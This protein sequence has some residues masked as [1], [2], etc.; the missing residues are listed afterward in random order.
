[1]NFL[2]IS[3]LAISFASSNI[4][5]FSPTLL[6]GD[7][8]VATEVTTATT[9][10]T[11]LEASHHHNEQQYQQQPSSPKTLSSDKKMRPSLSS[12]FSTFRTA[13]ATLVVSIFLS[14]AALSSSFLTVEPAWA[15]SGGGLDYAGIDISGQ[16]F[17]SS[18]YKGKDFT[19]VIAKGT[20][21]AGSNLQGCRFYKAFLVSVV[22]V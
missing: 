11:Y 10:T 8:F 12:S 14:Q 20:S 19:Q 5:A 17:S 18:N 2:V 7:R 22:R 9:T 16:D 13:L 1:M 4:D 3:I 6:F 15:V 21:F